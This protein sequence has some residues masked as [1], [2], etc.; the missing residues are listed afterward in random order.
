VLAGEAFGAEELVAAVDIRLALE[1]L[2]AALVWAI[3]RVIG[4]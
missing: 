4:V 2:V 3:A 1:G